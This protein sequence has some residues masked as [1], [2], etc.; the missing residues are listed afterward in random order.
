MP[1][2]DDDFDATL[3][4]IV[5]STY[6]VV[7]KQDTT[8]YHTTV[9]LVRDDDITIQAL[10][11]R[12]ETSDVDPHT[13][14]YN[15]GKHLRTEGYEAGAVFVAYE[16]DGDSIQIV[17][18]TPDRRQ[19]AAVLSIE[20]NED[21]ILRAVGSQVSHYMEGFEIVGTRNPAEEVLHG[22]MEM[23]RV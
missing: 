21:V 17:G 6:N 4:W 18:C 12:D 3:D 16:A 14:L 2:T 13:V 1:I 11:S 20:R 8:E 7:N 15:F 19:N 9:F 5:Q 22:M 23:G 10:V